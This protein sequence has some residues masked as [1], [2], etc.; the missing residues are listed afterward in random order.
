SNG[1]RT[2]CRTSSAPSQGRTRDGCRAS[3]RTQDTRGDFGG[4]VAPTD[5]NDGPLR[6]D[7]AREDRG[8][9]GRAGGLDGELRSRIE[10]PECVLDLAL[11]DEDALE[12]PAGPGGELAGE[13]RVEAVR[14]R[15]RRHGHRLS[16]GE[17]GVQRLAALG[18]DGDHARARA[19]RGRDAGDQPAA[20][21][22][23]DDGVGVG[24]V[25]LDLEP[26]GSLAGADE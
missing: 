25:L 9:R 26:H 18:L 15:R 24:R 7:L 17:R 11:A 5:Y 14:D 20:P 22:R 4:Y 12:V 23:D 13:R 19:D 1:S 10:E 8:G 16:G 21:D 3:S 6:I 2:S